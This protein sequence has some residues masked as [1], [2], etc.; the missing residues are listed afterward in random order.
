MCGD[1]WE[2]NEG[3]EEE[4]GPNGEYM[5]VVSCSQINDIEFRRANRGDGTVLAAG[6]HPI[7]WACVRFYRLVSNL[8]YS[9]TF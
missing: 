9:S 5:H 4:Q 6:P 3:G 1:D 7:R 8:F 2:E